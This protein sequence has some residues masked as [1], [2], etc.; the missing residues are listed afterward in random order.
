[1]NDSI[2]RISLDVH[3]P[4]SMETVY[5]KRGDT[6]RKICVSLVDG[7]VP[8]IIGEDCY[9]IFTAK[10]PDKKAVFNYCTIENNTITY[11]VTEQTVAAEGRVNC[12]IRLYGAD[13]KLITS[14]KFTISVFGT[15]YNDGDEI[16]S[17]DEFN[18][19]KELLKDLQDATDA[20]KLAAAATAGYVIQEVSGEAITLSDAEKMHLVSLRICGKTTQA[21]TPTP[22][23]P[24][25]LV[26][27]VYGDKLTVHVCGKNLFTGWTI[28]GVIPDTG[29]DYAV[30]TQRR[31]GYL[32]ILKAGQKYIVSGIPST[33][34]TFAAFY[35]ADK[36]FLSRTVGC[37]FGSR[38]LE[39][40]AKAKYF[41]FAIYENS[42]ATGTIAEADAMEKQTMIETGSVVTEY[43]PGA[44]QT[45]VISTPGGLRGLPVSVGGNYVDGN[46]QQ[47]ICDEID[48]DRGVYIK[49]IDQIV[50]DGSSDEYWTKYGTDNNVSFYVWPSKAVPGA[51]MSLCDRFANVNNAWSTQYSAAYGIY[52]DHPSALGKYFRAPNESVKTLE[53]WNTWLAQNPITLV[54][55]MAKPVETALTEAEIA[56][57]K[58]LHTYRWHTTVSNDGWAYMELAYLMDAKKYINSLNWSESTFPAARLAYVTILAS[59]WVVNG[60]VCSQVVDIE[61]ITPYSKIDL[62]P[63]VEQLTIFHDKDL[64]FVTENDDG[65][66]TVYAV[67]DKPQNDYTIQVAITEVAV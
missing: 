59:K 9:A 44:I 52:A 41:R 48:F 23:A 58:A 43:E 24:V 55:V 29:A 14:P 51:K 66:V 21:G 13:G 15:V 11:E 26:S 63:S 25:G 57:Y 33:L 46:G 3:N 5:A 49:R 56:A 22:N 2:K 61:G 54:Y 18:A 47:W 64:A 60:I 50:Y 36:A 42:G 6:G 28:G 31:T 10:K 7:G 35:D 65:V 1:M 38:V 37:A 62:L 67:G 45:A 4:S 39:P 16:E 12:E 8:Y 53:Q 32:P 30:T 20:A 34:Y 40:P 17:S 19:L 27:S